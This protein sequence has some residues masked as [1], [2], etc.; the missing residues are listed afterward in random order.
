[1]LLSDYISRQ[2]LRLLGMSCVINKA[3]IATFV[4]IIT[5]TCIHGVAFISDSEQSVFCYPDRRC[6]RLTYHN[7]NK[8]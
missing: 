7:A 4:L 2:T 8:D 5:C 3:N 6:E 1:M